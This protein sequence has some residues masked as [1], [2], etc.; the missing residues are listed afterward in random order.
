MLENKVLRK[1]SG[2]ETEE[3]SEVWRLPHNEQLHDLYSWAIIIVVVV[4]VDHLY[5]EYLQLD[6]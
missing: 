2:S 1:I 6:T 4:V 5:A 3:T